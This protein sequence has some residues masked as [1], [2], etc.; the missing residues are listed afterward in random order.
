MP[1]INFADP[2]TILVGV[3]LFILVLWLARETKKSW[4]MGI[5][6]FIFIGL[7]IAHTVRFVNVS[8]Q[9]QIIYK[10]VVNSITMDLVF[11]FLSFFTYLWVDDIEAK[12]GKKKS[13]DNSL[14]WLWKNV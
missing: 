1:I 9:S 13:I 11:I 5:L 4:I 10:A 6:L 12:S 7:L 14:D 8:G 2:F 3:I